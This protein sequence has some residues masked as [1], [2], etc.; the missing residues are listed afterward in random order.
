[1]KKMFKQNSSDS[2]ST[3]AV[4]RAQIRPQVALCALDT[5]SEAKLSF[6]WLVASPGTLTACASESPCTLHCAVWL[7]S[8]FGT[9]A[10]L[11]CCCDVYSPPLVPLHAS[12]TNLD[13]CC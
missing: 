1:M 3:P 6:A 10:P 9:D 7:R 4:S 8:L 5:S 11:K 2:H 13:R 12:S